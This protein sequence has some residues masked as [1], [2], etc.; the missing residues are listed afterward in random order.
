MKLH[1]SASTMRMLSARRQNGR[2]RASRSRGYALSR[3]QYVVDPDAFRVPTFSSGLRNPRASPF[4]LPIAGGNRSIHG[5][6]P[7]CRHVTGV[8]RGAAKTGLS[9]AFS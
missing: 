6:K 9:V 8:S 4:E 7:T 1:H 3:R 5:C 2:A